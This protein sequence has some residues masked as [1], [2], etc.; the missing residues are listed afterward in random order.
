MKDIEVLERVEP[1]AEDAPEKPP[2][3]EVNLAAVRA[4]EERAI[5]R[6]RED[7]LKD[8]LQVTVRAQAIFNALRKTCVALPCRSPRASGGLAIH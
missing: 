6:A 7:S 3:P 4:R 5:E 8:N 1:P 2:L